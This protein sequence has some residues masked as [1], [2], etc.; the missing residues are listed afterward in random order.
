MRPVRA[1][2]CSYESLRDGTVGIADLALMNDDLD[3]SIENQW[4]MSKRRPT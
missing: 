2:M 3:A 4:R 1:G